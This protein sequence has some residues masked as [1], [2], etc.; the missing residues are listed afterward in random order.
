[1]VILM[2][3]K[4][5]FNN[6]LTHKYTTLRTLWFQI[7][8]FSHRSK[9]CSTKCCSCL[10]PMHFCALIGHLDAFVQIGTFLKYLII[11]ISWFLLRWWMLSRR[12]WYFFSCQSHRM[13]RKTKSLAYSFLPSKI[14]RLFVCVRFWMRVCV[15]VC[16]GQMR[17][18][19]QLK[20]WKNMA[21][22]FQASNNDR[23]KELRAYT[24]RLFDIA[25][26]FVMHCIH[27]R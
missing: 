16:L 11:I 5:H 22:V 25:V 3:V 24:L 4:Q 12:W 2:L 1:M 18:W 17:R 7:S 10:T 8:I 15:Y 13:N 23:I 9:F 14:Y 20:K 26:R 21:V 19:A 6:G 27:S